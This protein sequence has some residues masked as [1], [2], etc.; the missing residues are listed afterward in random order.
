MRRTYQPTPVNEQEELTDLVGLCLWDVFSD[1][2]DVIAADGRVADIG[3]FRGAGAFLD[4]HL[5]RA[6]DSACGGDYMRFYMGTTWIGARAD[7]TPV[8]R[9]IFRRLRAL[10][11]DW[12]Y[13]F[14]E[15]YVTELGPSDQ[16]A[17][18]SSY[19]VSEAA[20]AELNAQK[21]R[22]E[23]ARLR[24]DIEEMNS[25]AREEAIDRPPPA[26]VTAYRQVYGHDPR[27]WPPA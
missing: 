21:Q 15:L 9:M 1:N 14:P 2:H 3:S 8:Y 4:E 7:L 11:A 23:T 17:E 25:R 26:T 10:G 24:S 22:A 12:V 20:V 18:L 27:G 19:S 16:G 5:S 13:H 6:H